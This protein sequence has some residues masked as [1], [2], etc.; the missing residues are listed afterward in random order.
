MFTGAQ[1]TFGA[2]LR[3]RQHLIHDHGQV[4]LNLAKVQKWLD[5]TRLRAPALGRKLQP[6]GSVFRR[7][8]CDPDRVLH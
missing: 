3:T 2:G 8:S 4:W 7:S 5:S 1:R 6:L